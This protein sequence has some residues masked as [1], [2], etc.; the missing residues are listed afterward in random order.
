MATEKIREQIEK[1]ETRKFYNNMVDRWTNENYRIDKEL[2]D[3]ITE[4]KKLLD[5]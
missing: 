1:L 3:Q 4:L 5:K 2:T